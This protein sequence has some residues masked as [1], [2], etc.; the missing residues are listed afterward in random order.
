[1]IPNEPD[2]LNY[3]K[4]GNMSFTG[5]YDF[6]RIKGMRLKH[7]DDVKLLGFNYATNPKTADKEQL[8]VHFFLPDYR[9]QQ[10][11]NNPQKYID[12][13]KQYKGIVSP[14]FSCYIGM[15]KAMQIFNVYRMA[16]LTAYYQ[17]YGVKVL[18]SVTWGEEDTYDWVFEWIPKGSA[19]VCSTVGCMQ[20]KDSTREFLKG[21]EKMCEII[22]PSD[23]I[24]YGKVIPEMNTIYPDFHRVPS[25][26][27]QRKQS[28]LWRA[29]KSWGNI[30]QADVK[31]IEYRDVV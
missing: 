10:V 18:P 25:L 13:F 3:Q 14:D 22:E 2:F 4:I 12:C 21:Y 28:S 29:P 31:K 26:M 20:N 23:I 11:W 1:M 17:R 16:F 27:E 6:P 19:V 5:P 9:F 30:Q 7:P 8:W 15:P 24:V